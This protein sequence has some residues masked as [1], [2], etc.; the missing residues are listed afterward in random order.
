MEE[1]IRRELAKGL[2]GDG[3]L[4]EAEMLRKNGEP[5]PVEIRGRALF[6]M[7]GRSVG[8]QGV[9]R[10]ITERKTAE[11]KRD[12]LEK[13]LIPAQ[14]MESGIVKQNNGFINVYS[15]L[16]VMFMSGYTANVIAHR[17]VLDNDVCF[18]QKPFSQTVL[19][20]KVR[21]ALGE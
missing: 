9:S 4:F 7:D 18:M 6:H 21:E 13:Q 20:N 12:S 8:F 16:K 1:S 11:R 19:A 17:G 3:V 14:K 2:Q 10:D 5:L 15:E